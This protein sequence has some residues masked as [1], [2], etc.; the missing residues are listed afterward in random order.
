MRVESKRKI[1]EDFEK[2]LFEKAKTLKKKGAKLDDIVNELIGDAVHEMD[3]INEPRLENQWERY[4][5]LFN[6]VITK[7]LLYCQYDIA[8][9]FNEAT[10]IKHTVGHEGITEVGLQTIPYRIVE[11]SLRIM[12]EEGIIKIDPRFRGLYKKIK[13]CE[14][15]GSGYERFTLKIGDIDYVISAEHKPGS[16]SPGSN[17]PGKQ[18]RRSITMCDNADIHISAHLHT[19]FCFFIGRQAS[20]N[21]SVFYKGATFNEYDSYGREG[22]WSPAVIGYEK[23]LVPKN[24]KYEGIYGVQFVLSDVLS[25]KDK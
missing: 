3:R 15:G 9:V 20:N 5:M 21:I 10:H 16:A 22:G 25:K 1:P 12:E 17:I 4:M 13:A 24:K 11:D 2:E 18:I 14:H 6:R 8:A 7:T 23:A 19:P